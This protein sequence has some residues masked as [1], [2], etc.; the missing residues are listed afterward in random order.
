MANSLIQIKQSFTNTVPVSLNVGELAYSYVSNSLFIGTPDNAGYI[1]IGGFSSLLR[2]DEAFHAANSGFIQANAS[3]LHANAAFIKANSGYESQNSS[4]NYANA[5]FIRANNSLNANLG[6]QVTGVTTFNSN[7]RASSNTTGDLVVTGGAAI[8]GNVYTGSIYITGNGLSGTQNAIVFGDGTTQNTSPAAIALSANLAFG[9]A[10]GAFAKSNAAYNHANAAFI[11]ANNAVDANLGG[12]ITATT[13][14][15]TNT[16]GALTVAGGVGIRGN[17][18][19]G[20]IVM[21]GNGVGGLSNTLTFPDG[22]VQNSS[23]VAIGNYAN[24]AFANANGAFAAANAAFANANGAFAKSNAAFAFANGAFVA[25]NLAFNQA[26]SGF[27]QANSAY[28]QANAA[29]QSQNATGQYAN[30]AYTRANN[31][32]SANVGGTVTGDV[33]ITGNLSV[34]GNTTYVNT[35]QVLIADNIITLNAA[36]NQASAPILNAGIEIDRGSAANVYVLWNESGTKWTVTNDGTN[37]YGIG[38]D[39][40]ESYANSAFIKSNA[41]F[42]H[43][44][45]AYISQ[46]ATG[47]YANS[48]FAQA[49]AAYQSQNATGQYA[50]SAFVHA[51]SAF[52]YGNATATYANSAFIRANNSLNANVGGQVTGDVTFVGNVTSNTITTTGSNGSI[53]GANAI[54]TNY[55]FAANGNVDLYIYS[56]NAYANANAGF[57]KANAAFANA[58][59]AFIAA[60]LAFNQANAAFANANGAFAKANGSYNHA[61]ASFIWAN[62]A[63]TQA[64]TDKANLVNGGY[65]AQLYS[66]G[67]FG[68]PTNIL[69]NTSGGV[70]YNSGPGVLGI[71]ANDAYDYTGIVLDSSAQ[72]YMYAATDVVIGTNLLGTQQQSIFRSNGVFE[73]PDRILFKNTRGSIQPQGTD[74]LQI[75]SNTASDNAGVYLDGSTMS[76][77]YGKNVLLQTNE[78]APSTYDFYFNSDGVLVLPGVS[79]QIGR[80]GYLNGIDLYNNNGGSGYVRM[81]YADQSYMWVDP[82][83][84][85]VQTAGTYTWDFGTDGQITFPDSTKQNTAFIGYGV[86]NVARFTSNSGFDH[87]NSAFATANVKTQTYVQAT[88]PAGANVDDIWID[89]S[90]GIQYVYINSNSANQWVEFSAY[91]S[92]LNGT[93]NIQFADQTIF[94]VNSAQDLVISNPSTAN[95]KLISGN[96]VITGNLI[97]DATG[98]SASFNNITAVY[99][100]VNTSTTIANSAAVNIVGSTGYFTQVPTSNGYMMQITGNDNTTSR[101]VNDSAGVGVYSAFIGRH[102]RGTHQNPTAA[103]AGDLLAR[104]SGNGY[105]ASGYGVNAGGASMDVYATE[106][107][108]DTSRGSKLVIA[109]TA[110]GTNARTVTATFDANTSTFA[111]TVAPQKGFIYP[112]RKANVANSVA[113]TI[114]FANDAIVRCTVNANMTVSFTNFQVGKIVD[115]W[116]TNLSGLSRTVTH[117][118]TATNST[119][120]DTVQAIPSTST[121]KFQYYSIDGDAA[122]TFVSIIQG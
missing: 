73:L 51:N 99:F 79:G 17:V 54:F 10:N 109:T 96:T 34:I 26:N 12:T 76:I 81:N 19:T 1:N 31:S 22:T 92:P 72:A 35:S 45:A 2:Y 28:A 25:A 67:A 102:A 62:A 116:I 71:T 9:N 74:A 89:S 83:G 37:Y 49:N 66:N 82:A 118:L 43:A 91:S 40:A 88:S 53:S 6:G 58:N 33:T 4:G 107:Y 80:S 11:R 112:V 61:N 93:A 52:T 69:F 70:I 44:N 32:L 46:N 106:N 5:A 104:F 7:T 114:D 98:K 18:Y 57:A 86:D 13:A 23:P 42:G 3:F 29:Y 121:S 24:S 117:G 101:V 48:A 103:Q 41:A 120:N 30:A 38:S 20:S 110:N 15:I 111:G 100:R 47:Q 108:T 21:T 77:L 119:N 8:K 122:N 78:G 85:H 16:S 90:S 56:S 55:I 113:V 14:A 64:N 105:G 95:I 97:A 115:L 50:N 39:A 36:I 94:T 65:T 27:I 63:Y 68:L 84:A 59:G 60:N 75:S 87:A